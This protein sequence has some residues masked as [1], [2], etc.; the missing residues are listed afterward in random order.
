MEEK[1]DKREFSLIDVVIYV[2]NLTVILSGCYWHYVNLMDAL[3]VWYF[4]LLVE[5]KKR[6]IILSILHLKAY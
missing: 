5:Q 2:S 1:V 4:K 3:S 6:G